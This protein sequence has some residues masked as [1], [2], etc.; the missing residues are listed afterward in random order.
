MSPETAGLFAVLSFVH[1][2]AAVGLEV[3]QRGRPGIEAQRWDVSSS[4]SH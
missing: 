1:P 2:V 4:S 3:T